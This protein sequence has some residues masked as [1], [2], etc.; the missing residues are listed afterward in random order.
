MLEK[1]ALLMDEENHLEKHKNETNFDV[2][3][4]IAQTQKG[5]CQG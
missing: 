5:S 3:I 2:P 1:E 4:N